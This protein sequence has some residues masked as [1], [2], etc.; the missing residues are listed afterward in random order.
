[1]PLPVD[2]NLGNL[3]GPRHAC[4]VPGSDTATLV[5]SLVASQ[6]GNT[7]GIAYFN[8]SGLVNWITALP[9]PGNQGFAV[10]VYD[11]TFTKNPS[12]LYATT[13]SNPG[14]AELTYSPAGLQYAGDICC[15]SDNADQYVGTGL[16][17]DGTLRCIRKLERSG[18]QSSTGRS[19]PSTL[20]R[21]KPSWT[22]SYPI[23]ARAKPT[24]STSLANILSFRRQP[25]SPSTRRAWRKR[26]RSR[27]PAAMVHSWFVGARTDLP[28]SLRIRSIPPAL[29]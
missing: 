7:D 29:L 19:L 8:G 17:T 16:A 26:V 24:T 20:S 27:S 22:A 2:P 11:F 3:K 25:F 28:S 1:M 6:S 23:R 10:S 15:V 13:S 4:A 5:A 18:I 9:P 14:Y 12:T 21:L